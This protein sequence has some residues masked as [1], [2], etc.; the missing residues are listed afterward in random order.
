[1]RRTPRSNRPTRA[2]VA[3][4]VSR[5]RGLMVFM[6]GAALLLVAA[7]AAALLSG[8]GARALA[9]LQPNSLGLSD[10]ATGHLRASVSIAGTP[11]RVPVNGRQVWVTSDEARTAS[12]VDAGTSLILR[13]I[14][15]GEFPSDFA[16]GA[17]AV[18]VIDRVRGRLVKIS[19]DYA[20]VVGSAAVRS[21]ETSSTTEDR[22]DLDPWSIAAGRGRGLK[23]VKRGFRSLTSGSSE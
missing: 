17:G 8:G 11:A 4:V 22:Y 5:R 9:S 12:L 14:Q 13:V 1:M 19:P 7:I 15:I 21:A 3:T 6:V 23:T 20:T 10:P 18:W 2:S 16:V